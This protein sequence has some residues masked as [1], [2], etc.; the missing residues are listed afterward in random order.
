MAFVCSRSSYQCHIQD[1]TFYPALLDLSKMSVTNA[2]CYCRK[3]SCGDVVSRVVMAFVYLA[4]DAL[5]FCREYA[6]RKIST[7]QSHT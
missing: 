2:D 1:G 6:D 7:R 3:D 4:D 5:D